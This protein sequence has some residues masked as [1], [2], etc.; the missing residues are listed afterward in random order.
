[1]LSMKAKYALRALIVLSA[2][3]KKMQGKAIAK[4]AD[5][6]SKFLEAIL[7]E[8]KHNGIVI[9][10]RGIF[11]GYVLSKH[12]RDIFLGDVIRII[13]GPLAPIR[14]ASLTAYQK[15]MVMNYVDVLIAQGDALFTEFQMETVNEAT[16]YY[17]QALE[18]LGP[19]PEVVG[20]CGVADESQRPYAR[21]E[22]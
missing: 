12:P 2:H 11:G 21:A 4:E 8:L 20:D 1:M 7:N 15:C 19:R 16:L 10:K 3:D 22:T 17:V 18:I 14:C 6:P 5:V 9:A 13:D